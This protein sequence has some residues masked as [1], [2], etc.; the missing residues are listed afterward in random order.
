[1]PQQQLPFA[2]AIVRKSANTLS[3]SNNASSSQNDGIES[4]EALGTPASEE[5]SISASTSKP[6]TSWVF[7]HMPDKDI[8][9]RYYNKRGK[10]E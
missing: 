10:K 6:R 9:T 2:C 5:S 4:Q 7:C 3:T 1:M 8:E